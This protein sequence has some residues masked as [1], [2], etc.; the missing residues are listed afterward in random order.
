MLHSPI[1]S[2]CTASAHTLHDRCLFSRVS[3]SVTPPRNI[4]ITRTP[5]AEATLLCRRL[6]PAHAMAQQAFFILPCYMQ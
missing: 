5:G 2:T 3:T 1:T 4:D 6:L